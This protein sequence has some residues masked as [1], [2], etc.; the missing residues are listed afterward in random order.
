MRLPKTKI[1]RLILLPAS[2]LVAQCQLAPV[3]C[4]PS[5]DRDV[6]ARLLEARI[7]FCRPPRFRRRDRYGQDPRPDA[8]AGRSWQGP[9][10]ARARKVLPL[11]DAELQDST[12]L[13][14]EQEVHLFRKMNFLKYQAARL[15]EAIDPSRARSADLD[16]V[17][18]LLR[19]AGAIR[20]RIIRSNLGL[21]VS[22]VKK[23]HRA[24]PGFLR[25]GL[26]GKPRVDPGVGAIRLRARHPVQHV[27]DLGDLQR[28]CPANPQRSEPPPPVRHRPR[29]A[30]EALTDHRDRGRA[31]ATDHESI[32]VMIPRCSVAL[33]DREQTI[34]ARRFGLAGDKQTLVESA[35]SWG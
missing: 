26:R 18:E 25:P 27:C 30:V 1:S 11:S 6:C 29:G 2:A 33:D 13:T 17:E 16:R 28:L 3:E 4:G 21:V 5:P 32:S 15:H 8:R 19:E 23:M 10:Q 34:I 24:L 31:D 20:N 9:G 22:I 12:L 35:E 14:C 7:K